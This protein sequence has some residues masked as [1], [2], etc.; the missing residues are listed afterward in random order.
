MNGISKHVQDALETFESELNTIGQK[1]EKAVEAREELATFERDHEALLEKHTD[2][3]RAAEA[4]AGE[5]QQLIAEGQSVT[6]KYATFKRDVEAALAG[7]S[8]KASAAKPI[9]PSPEYPSTKMARMS[10]SAGEDLG[11]ED[12]ISHQLWSGN[13]NGYT[14][15]DKGKTLT[16]V[17]FKDKSTWSVMCQVYDRVYG[18]VDRNLIKF[19]RTPTEMRKHFGGSGD[20]LPSAQVELVEPVT[21]VVGRKPKCAFCKYEIMSEVSRAYPLTKSKCATHPFHVLCGVFVTHV[22]IDDNRCFGYESNPM[23]RRC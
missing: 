12:H 3:K 19:I 22:M 4:S 21:G 16:L 11:D 9:P 23:S 8:G 18:T 20:V 5:E 14:C 10:A 15:E 1:I 13:A 6:A 17:T 7:L 2:L